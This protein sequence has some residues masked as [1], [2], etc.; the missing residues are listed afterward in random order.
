MCACVCVCTYVR[1]ER[2]ILVQSPTVL[3]GDAFSGL[4]LEFYHGRQASLGKGIGAEHSA[5]R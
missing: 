5:Y 1:E 3:E 4:Q 2:E